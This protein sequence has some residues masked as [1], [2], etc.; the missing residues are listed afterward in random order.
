M[1]IVLILIFL[2]VLFLP[3]LSG[4]VE[5]NLEVFLFIMGLIAAT[6]SGALNRD[7]FVEASL[8]P[9]KISVAVFG[10]GLLFKWFQRPLERGITGMNRVIPYRVFIALS[11]IFMGLISSVITAIIAAL[12][13]VV[14]VQALKMDHTSRIRY[15]VISC[16]AI[17]LGAALTPIGEPLS[18]IVVSKL[19]KNFFF[20]ID[21]IGPQVIS[22][23]ILLGL[24]AAFM[25]KK[26]ADNEYSPKE[27]G[28]EGHEEILLRALKIYFFVMGLE[29]LGEGFEPL[30]DRY[31]ITLAPQFLYWVNMIS[32]V[33]DNATLAATEIGHHM[34]ILSLRAIL[35]GLLISGGMLIPGN[36][37]NIVS[38]GK[39]KLTSKEW[40]KLGVPLGLI[41][42]AIFYFSLF[43][44]PLL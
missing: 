16:F 38:A 44:F 37:P 36:I 23:L 40:A 43:D 1:M 35:L 14:I 26:R 19:D 27:Y 12:V 25:V 42:M 39:L 33:L 5:R 22:A 41:L 15:V 24:L 32:A 9:I 6:L 10:A 28:R 34:G 3:L 31:L 17:G 7:L 30:I 29:F 4:V 8:D 18:T 20:L 2:L 21:L 13:L 11:V